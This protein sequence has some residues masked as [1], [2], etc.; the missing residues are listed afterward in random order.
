VLLL[1]SQQEIYL[2]S[3]FAYQIQVVEEEILKSTKER[4]PFNKIKNEAM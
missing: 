2:R 1:Q 4:A 3:G